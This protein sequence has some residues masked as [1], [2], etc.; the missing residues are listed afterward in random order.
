MIRTKWPI[1]ISLVLLSLVLPA[2]WQSRVWGMGLPRGGLE[3]EKFECSVKLTAAAE[4]TVTGNRA[5]KFEG[6]CTVPPPPKA[7]G[8]RTWV[9]TYHAQA[10]Y[11]PYQPWVLSPQEAGESIKILSGTVPAGWGYSSTRTK[12]T[13][14]PFVHGEEA[15]QGE[16]SINT[17]NPWN[18]VPTGGR[19][20]LFAGKVPANQVY[21]KIT[22]DPGSVWIVSPGKNE[23]IPTTKG[24]F[25][26]KF[27]NQSYINP[28][29]IGAV[30]LEWGRFVGGWISHSGPPP[31]V[32][33]YKMTQLVS[34]KDFPNPGK[35]RVR[36]MA[37]PLMQWTPWREFSIYKYIDPSQIQKKIIK[38]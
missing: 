23:L 9:V 31:Y 37:S 34:I 22:P 8:V 12:C 18:L 24:V 1:L 10:S 2:A 14:D 32:E 33:Y 11:Q 25:E 4:N 17:N 36:A 38:P 16:K 26:V 13:K 5:Y 29:L 7:T 15:C 30:K 27:S 28:N 21:T 19:A 35:Y 6:A 3:A 20:L